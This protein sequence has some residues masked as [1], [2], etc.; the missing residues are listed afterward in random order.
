MDV[1]SNAWT[2]RDE[3]LAFSLRHVVSLTRTLQCKAEFLLGSEHA[4]CFQKLLLDVTPVCQ[5]IFRNRSYLF[6]LC[7]HLLSGLWAVVASNHE[8]F[9]RIRQHHW[10]SSF[11][12]PH[13]KR[14]NEQ[15]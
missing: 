7:Y 9:V 5:A 8:T 3:F 1:T 6:T 15:K 4:L 2:E 11:N 13:L 10:R 12:V 14:S